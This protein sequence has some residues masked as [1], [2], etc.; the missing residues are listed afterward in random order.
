[1]NSK[2]ISKNKELKG[3]IINIILICVYI[4]L[5]VSGLVLFKLGTSQNFSIS[6]TAGNFSLNM[7]LKVIIGLFC[8]LCSFLLYMFLVSQFDLSYIVPITQGII[9]VLI[10]LAS[11]NVFKESVTTTGII[12]TI[13]VI[14][15]II[16]LNIK[17]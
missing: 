12:G 1:M 15:G 7:N 5:T 13:L 2:V 14:A 17:K 9:Y 4:T 6:L 3:M 11:I 16:L 10:F 8:Y